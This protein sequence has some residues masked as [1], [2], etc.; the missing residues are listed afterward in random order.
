MAKVLRSAAAAAL[1]VL[2][3]VSSAGGAATVSVPAAERISQLKTAWNQAHFYGDV[4]ALD[5]LWAPE[6][7]VIVPG[8]PPFSMSDLLTMRCSMKAT[9]TQYAIGT[10][11]ELDG[12]WKVVAYLASVAP[13]P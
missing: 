8:M 10:Y 2:V 11:A 1:F 9:L 4:D 7:T 12:D 5:R 6:L 3:A 13:Q